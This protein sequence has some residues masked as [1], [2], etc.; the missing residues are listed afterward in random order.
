[1]VTLVLAQGDSPKAD[2]GTG[3]VIAPYVRRQYGDEL[4]DVMVSI[5]RLIDAVDLLNPGVLLDDTPDAHP[6]SGQDRRLA[7][8][9]CWPNRLHMT[10]C[11]PRST[12]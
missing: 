2:Q 3:R 8:C 4:Y 1:M 5:K 6:V 7:W 12:C 11:A 9:Q 10:S